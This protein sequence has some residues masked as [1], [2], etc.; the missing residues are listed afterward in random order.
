M[1][2][3]GKEQDSRGSDHIQ[4][5]QKSSETIPVVHRPAVQ[6]ILKFLGQI[7]ILCSLQLL[8]RYVGTDGNALIPSL[9]E[10]DISLDVLGRALFNA[11]FDVHQ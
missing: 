11:T 2:T 1:K 4:S 8:R 5:K 6:A 10:R 7:N 3:N 9:L